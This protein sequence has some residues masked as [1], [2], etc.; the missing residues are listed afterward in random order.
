MFDFGI[1]CRFT[2]R[3]LFPQ[4]AEIG[5]G[6]AYIEVD[7]MDSMEIVCPTYSIHD[8]SDKYEHLI[9]HQV[10]KSSKLSSCIEIHIFIVACEET[11]TDDDHIKTFL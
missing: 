2:D 11:Q 1:C 3:S 8:N 9:V 6:A 10:T 4:D 7:A 5:A